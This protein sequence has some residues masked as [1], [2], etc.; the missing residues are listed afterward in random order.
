M[1]NKKYEIVNPPSITKFC[2]K[3]ATRVAMNIVNAITKAASL[4]KRP[5]KTNIPPVNSAP[6]AINAITTGIGKCNSFPNQSSKKA[7]LFG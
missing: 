5:V 7:L 2:P 4:V 3:F 6:L 1:A